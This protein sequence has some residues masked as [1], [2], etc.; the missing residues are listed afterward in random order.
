MAV[1]QSKAYRSI[2]WDLWLC[3]SP[4]FDQG[5]ITRTLPAH[6]SIFN[7]LRFKGIVW[8]EFF[9]GQGVNFQQI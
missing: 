6:A 4:V 3:F 2:F 7:E 8:K 5:D 9:V 1:G